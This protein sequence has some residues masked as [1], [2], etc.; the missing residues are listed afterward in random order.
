MSDKQEIPIIPEAVVIPAFEESEN[1]T[2][3]ELKKKS[4]K[5]I[6]GSDLN[7]IIDILVKVDGITPQ[8]AVNRLNNMVRKGSLLIVPLIGTKRK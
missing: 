8:E 3:T 5:W 2:Q 1:K 4:P 6:S 7:G